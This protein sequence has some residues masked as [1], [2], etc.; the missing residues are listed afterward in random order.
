MRVTLKHSNTHIPTQRSDKMDY[1]Y[2][3]NE[4]QRFMSLVDRIH[5][6]Y[7]VQMMKPSDDG[8]EFRLE[9]LYDKKGNFRITRCLTVSY[10]GNFDIRT[11]Y[12]TVDGWYVMSKTM[13]ISVDFVDDLVFYEKYIGVSDCYNLVVDWYGFITETEYRTSQSKDD[14]IELSSDDTNDLT[15]TENKE[16]EN[17]A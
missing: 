1:E 11:D 9:P 16:V 17:D 5:G 6:V 14:M 13:H 12:E 10:S 15:E 3:R 4:T 8:I 7:D 2:D